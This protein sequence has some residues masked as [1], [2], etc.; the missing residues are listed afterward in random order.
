M[1]LIAILRAMEKLHIPFGEEKRI[2]SGFGFSFVRWM[3]RRLVCTI[4]SFFAHIEVM[5]VRRN[6]FLVI[7][8]RFLL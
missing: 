8:F 2:V 4:H 1:S 3:L 6:A 7:Q 5:S